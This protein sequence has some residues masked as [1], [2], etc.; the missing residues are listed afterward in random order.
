MNSGVSVT[1]GVIG[2]DVDATGADILYVDESRIEN[3]EIRFA[4]RAR[5]RCDFLSCLSLLSHH[6]FVMPHSLFFY[7]TLVCR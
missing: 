4:E 6:N 1:F 7:G 2:F 3:E 5:S